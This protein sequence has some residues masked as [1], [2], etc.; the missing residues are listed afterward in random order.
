MIIVEYP[1]ALVLKGWHLLLT[2]L[3]MD[4]NQA[5]LVALVLLVIT[6]RSL[7][8]PLYYRQMRSGRILANLRPQLRQLEADYADRHDQASRKELMNKRKEI[9]RENNY[10]MADGCLPSLVLVPVIIGLYRL[11]IRIARPSEGLEAAHAGFGP[12][13]GADV[14]SFLKAEF[15]GVPLPAYFQMPHD[16][17]AILGTTRQDVL[18]VA[19]PLAIIASTL[20]LLGRITGPESARNG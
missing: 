1:V 15:F 11:L 18:H 19:L 9:Q 10:K 17:L 13:T 4:H 14:D 16:Q 12:L 5:W 6:I 8:L 20:P 3:G 7:L 2:A